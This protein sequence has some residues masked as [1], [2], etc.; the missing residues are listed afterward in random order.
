MHLQVSSTICEGR[1]G[2][3]ASSEKPL[4][5]RRLPRVDDIGQLTHY[6]P[7]VQLERATLQALYLCTHM[8]TPGHVYHRTGANEGRRGLG[9]SRFVASPVTLCTC[10]KII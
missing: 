10:M 7:C 6:R 4:G 1:T 9:H 8:H 3:V 2:V 5:S